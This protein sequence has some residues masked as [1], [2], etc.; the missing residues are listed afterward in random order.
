M[1]A[2]RTRPMASC[3][4]T[5]TA[6]AKMAF[7]AV[8]REARGYDVVYVNEHLALL[9]VLAARLAG[10]PVMIRMMVDGAWEISHRKG[11]IGG[12]DINVF[13]TKEYG[14]QVKLVRRLQSWWWQRCG[15]II[16]CNASGPQ[17]G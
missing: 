7:F 11:W 6:M 16:A 1:R 8:W 10:K 17:H 12:D 14:W 3:S 15:R 9:H 4:G 2:I 5:S 13:E